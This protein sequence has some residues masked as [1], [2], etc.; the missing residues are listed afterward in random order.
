M[1][2]TEM[3]ADNRPEFTDAAGRPSDTAPGPRG[4][5]MAQLGILTKAQKKKPTLPHIRTGV[6]GKPNPND[7]ENAKLQSSLAEKAREHLMQ[8]Q[9]QGQQNTISEQDPMQKSLIARTPMMRR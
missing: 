3:P 1:A 2:G 6:D 7:L 5:R 4:A 9:Q 8:I